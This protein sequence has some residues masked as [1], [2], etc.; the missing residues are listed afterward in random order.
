LSTSQKEKERLTDEKV[1]QAMQISELKITNTA[2]EKKLMVPVLLQQNETDHNYRISDNS[3]NSSS[4]EHLSQATNPISG[5][6]D[7][8]VGAPANS[9]TRGK[10]ELCWRHCPVRKNK[11]V[12]NPAGLEAGLNDR[13]YIFK[14]L[15]N[16][17]GY[18]CATVHVHK[19]Y[20]MLSPTHN[21]N[22]RVDPDMRWSDLE[23]I[24]WEM[25][26]YGRNDTTLS[27]YEIPLK[28]GIQNKGWTLEGGDGEGNYTPSLYVETTKNDQGWDH[29]HQLEMLTFQQGGLEDDDFFVWNITRNFY[30]LN[31]NQHL[32]KNKNTPLSVISNPPPLSFPENGKHWRTDG[33][34]Y[35]KFQFAQHILAIA[36]NIWEDLQSFT[37]D[38]A[39]LGVFHIRRGDAQG[40]CN[41]TL[42]KMASYIPCS[43]EGSHVLGNITLLIS[44]DEK[45]PEYLG[46]VYSMLEAYPHV[47]A[48]SLDEL[49]WKHIRQYSVD[50]GT[51]SSR[52][53][54]NYVVFTVMHIIRW[55]RVDFSIEQRRRELCPDCEKLVNKKQFKGVGAA[56]H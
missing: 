42:P 3:N 35:W 15:I 34:K 52:L 37:H 1:A 14:Q 4:S 45:D 28:Y 7:S 38:N 12:Y 50:T 20:V 19:P 17:A 43:F 18:L 41:T 11:I 47:Q 6:S 39:T 29:F 16:I 54:N 53:L 40:Q 5:Q 9:K 44:T 55:D 51:M 2:I 13:F 46:A 31:L 25:N 26:H 33:C 22:Q 27:L 36:D 49:T 30:D 8:R 56:G 23:V 24:T 10:K 32:K 21:D 48:R